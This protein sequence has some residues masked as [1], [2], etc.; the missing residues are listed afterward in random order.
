VIYA[1]FIIGLIVVVIV[2]WA[3]VKWIRIKKRKNKGV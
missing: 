2:I 3:V 1:P